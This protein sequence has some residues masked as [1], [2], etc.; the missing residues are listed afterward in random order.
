MMSHQRFSWRHLYIGCVAS[1]AIA[2]TLVMGGLASA[3]E[4]VRNYNVQF[5]ST[6]PVADGVVSAGEWD[7]ASAAAGSWQLLRTNP[8]EPDTENNRFRMLWDATNLY[9]LYETA[10]NQWV[11]EADINAPKPDISFSADN[12]NIYF[13]PNTDGEMN[14]VP[15]AEVDGYQVAF[16]QPTHPTGGAL[17]S[18]NANRQGVGFF[19][20]AH[21]NNGF[22]DQAFWNRGGSQVGGDALQDIVVAQRNG[23]TGGV[24]EMVFPWAN[25]NALALAAGPVTNDSDFNSDGKVD[26]GDF[27]SWQR[28]VGTV[29]AVKANGDADLDLDVDDADLDLWAAANGEDTRV[30]TGLNHPEAP[31][32]NDVW[33][34]VMSRINGLGD[35]GNFLPIWN[36]HNDQSF[37]FRPH[38]TITFLGA[39]AGGIGAVPEPASL[40]LMAMAVAA[41][42]WARRRRT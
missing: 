40:A 34:F 29:G 41:A 19:T 1:A 28:G 3:Q 30:P 27:L 32:N 36:W 35:V 13:D 2:M 9:I 31:D 10:F 38:G 22:G 6:A 24:A 21:N 5:T 37:T 23:A 17:I 26:G 4:M 25:F 39:P 8:P 7:A 14:D 12:L 16:N 18:T 11:S 15:D 42:G 20:E 33:F